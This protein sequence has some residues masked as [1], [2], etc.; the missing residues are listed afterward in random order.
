MT[1]E[2]LHANRTCPYGG[3]VDTCPCDGD[4]VYTAPALAIPEIKIR[5]MAQR[6]YACRECDTHMVTTTN[7]QVDCYPNCVGTCRHIIKTNVGRPN[8]NEVVLRKQT[9][10]RYVREWNGP[11]VR[12]HT[13]VLNT[14]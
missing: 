10:H 14:D 13:I 12:D 4:C 1:N 2:Q 6:V 11:L 5:P 9:A 8:E 3:G 7:H